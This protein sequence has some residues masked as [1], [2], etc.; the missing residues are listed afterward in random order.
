MTK[1]AF[2]CVS[3]VLILSWALLFLVIEPTHHHE[4]N[5][6]HHDCGICLVAG[7]PIEIVVHFVLPTFES[8]NCESIA[9]PRN[10]YA[11]K[12]PVFHTSRS[13]PAD[14]PA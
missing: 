14:L 11:S 6:C 8:L 4:D 10:R 13:P 1:L 5:E 9:I 3:S 7:Q 12:P 2:K